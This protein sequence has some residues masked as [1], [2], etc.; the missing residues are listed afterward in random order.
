MEEEDG[1]E[2]APLSDIL[3]F[4]ASSETFVVVTMDMVRRAG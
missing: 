1:V 4:L 2:G 3:S